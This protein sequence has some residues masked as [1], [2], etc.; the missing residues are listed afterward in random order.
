MTDDPTDPR[1]WTGQQKAAWVATQM[2]HGR[3]FTTSDVARVL[4]MSRTGAWKMLNL[5]ACP[6]NAVFYKYDGYLEDGFWYNADHYPE[7]P[8]RRKPHR[9]LMTA[10]EFRASLQ[11]T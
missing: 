4:G 6:C 8:K 11:K 3:T 2:A 10:R 7:P 5:I 9:R 1:E